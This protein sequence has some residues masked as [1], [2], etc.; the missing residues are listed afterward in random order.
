MYAIESTDIFALM[1]ENKNIINGI[2]PFSKS[3]LGLQIT[4]CSSDLS[5][6]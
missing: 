3:C 2:V 1:L 6:K 5:G 4:V